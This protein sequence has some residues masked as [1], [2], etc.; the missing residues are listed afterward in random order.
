MNFTGETP[1]VDEIFKMAASCVKTIT[2]GEE[3]HDCTGLPKE[4]IMEFFEQ[5]SSKQ[6]MQIQEFFETMPKLSHTLKVTN[7]NTK[8]ESDVVLEGLASFFA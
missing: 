5:L 8:V 6:F 3:V 2:E 4:E 7:P 1:G